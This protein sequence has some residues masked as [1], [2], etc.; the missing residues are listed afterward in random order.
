LL[1]P[2]TTTTVL[3]AAVDDVTV[4]ANQNTDIGAVVLL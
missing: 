1:D 2:I 4:T 3:T